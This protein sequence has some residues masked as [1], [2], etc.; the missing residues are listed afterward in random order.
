VR[1][2]FVLSWIACA[3]CDTPDDEGGID[4]S[5]ACD[6]DGDLHASVLCPGG[7]DCDDADATVHPGA[8]EVCNDRDD[9]CD[10]ELVAIPS[11]HPD[12]DGDGYG[13]AAHPVAECDAPTGHVLDGGDCDDANP[14][15]SPAAGERCDNAIDDDCDGTAAVSVDE[16]GDG[17][18]SDACAGGDDCDDASADVHPGASEICGDGIDADCSGADGSCAYVGDYDLSKADATL[19]TTLADADAGRLVEVGDVTGDGIGDVLLAALG[20]GGTGGGYVMAGP[21]SGEVTLDERAHRVSSSGATSGAGRSIGLGDVSGDG[22]A[23]LAFGVPYSGVN[24]QYLVFGPVTGDVAFPDGADAWLVGRPGTFA[25]HGSDVGD[26][27][28]DGVDDAIVGAYYDEA[29]VEGAGIVFVEYGPLSGQVKLATDADVA[30]AGDSAQSAAGRALRSG[31]DVDGDGLDDLA[32]CAPFDDRG[33]PDSG[34][35]YVLHGPAA[36]GTLADADGVLVG[37]RPAAYA[38]STM[39]LGDLDGDG[40]ADVAATL[41]WGPGSVAVV[42]GPAEGEHD[43]SA[44]ELVIGGESGQDLL[45][46]GLAAGDVDADGVDELLIGAP[47]DATFGTLGGAAFLVFGP[48]AGGW[49]IGDVAQASFWGPTAGDWTGQGPAIGDLD[50]DG[51]G[52]VVLGGPGI[53]AGGGAYVVFPTK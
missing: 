16:D 43:L 5:A 32:V 33:G 42:A 7:D 4:R 47:G 21:V 15:V 40:R 24:G 2:T 38:G 53:T 17:F 35:V 14:D 51:W 1:A 46:A 30:I 41:A 19:I 45:G 48:P 3:A 37:G 26:L 6:W 11:W 10:G 36:V 20:A 22:L 31:A 44:A 18:G 9:D 27:D 49:D 23:D 28:G 50:G 29:D 39:A 12:V 13:D 52:E 25:G 34:S 8:V